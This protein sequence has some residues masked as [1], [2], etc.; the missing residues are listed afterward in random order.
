MI[1]ASSTKTAVTT[2]ICTDDKASPV[3]N[4]YLPSYCP[5]YTD[6]LNLGDSDFIEITGL[7]GLDYAIAEFQYVW[8]YLYKKAS[9]LATRCA[10]CF[11]TWL[12]PTLFCCC[13]CCCCCSCYPY[14]PR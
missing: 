2:D 12:R 13:G 4:F 11:I 5:R 8:K 10:I 9:A 14:T 7:K 6:Y 1:L 3:S